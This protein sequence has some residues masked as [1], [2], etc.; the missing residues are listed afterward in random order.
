MDSDKQNPVRRLRHDDLAQAVRLSETAGWNQTAEDWARYLDLSEGACYAI[1]CDGVLAATG[2]AVCYG[3]ELAWIGMVLTL[4]AY[5][6][7]GLARR[8]FRHTVEELDQRGVRCVKLDATSMGRELYRPFGFAEECAVE[9][10]SRPAGEFTSAELAGFDLDAGLDREAFG[11]DRGALL[12]NLARC[13]AVSLP[14][15]G[16]AMGRPGRVTTHFGPC[17][18]RTAAAARS[19]LEWFLARHSGEAVSWDLMPGNTHAVALAK[20]FGFERRRGLVRMRRG[21][22][23]TAFP[24]QVYA[25][26]GFEYG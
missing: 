2:G 19:F 10:W 17:V 5:R 24:S 20:E 26:A 9:R 23:C 6:G 22:D 8:I 13:D 18:S 25:I 3:R 15:A 16:Y 12:G 1:D 14:A 21:G 11:A 7:R 4:P